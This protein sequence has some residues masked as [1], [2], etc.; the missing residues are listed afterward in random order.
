M[1]RFS[2]R[3]GNQKGT[4]VG[5]FFLVLH[6][7]T[8]SMASDQG[9]YLVSMAFSGAGT[10]ILMTSQFNYLLESV[11]AGRRTA[12]L[13]VNVLLANSAVLLGSL[14]GPL[15]AGATGAAQALIILAVLRLLAGGLIYRFGK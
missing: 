7:L 15:I 14:I 1:A 12:W 2:R 5:A 4:A 3:V 9:M 10:G 13:S 8:L 11:P 6:A